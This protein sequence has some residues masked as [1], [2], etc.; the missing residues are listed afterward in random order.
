MFFTGFKIFDV[1]LLIFGAAVWCTDRS[2]LNQFGRKSV[3]LAKILQKDGSGLKKA[4]NPQIHISPANIT[5]IHKRFRA[6]Q[7]WYWLSQKKA[8]LV[9]LLLI[10]ECLVIFAKQDLGLI[11]V[12]AGILMVATLV[13]IAGWRTDKARVEA[14]SA[15]I[16]YEDR[17]WFEYR[18]A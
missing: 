9:W 12:E 5:Y 3:Y 6:I 18:Q 1:V 2:Y 17:L 8:S 15:L 11:I 7:R 13:M 14:E 10:Q 16:R 4:L